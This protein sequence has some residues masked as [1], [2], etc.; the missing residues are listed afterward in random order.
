MEI[1]VLAVALG[2]F[3]GAFVYLLIQIIHK[4]KVVAGVGHLDV[5]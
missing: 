2:L 1:C 3:V 5:K 4:H